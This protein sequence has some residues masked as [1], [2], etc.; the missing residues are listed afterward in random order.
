MGNLSIAIWDLIVL[1]IILF[2]VV[3]GAI[4]GFV[5][6][7]ATIAALV[8][9]FLFAE[10]LSVMIAPLIGVKEPLNRWIA[11]FLL[12]V[13]LSFISFAIARAMKEYIEEAKFTEYDKHM[14][15]VFGL[16]KG[17]AL[18]LVLTFFSV[19][20]SEQAKNHILG[21]HSGRYAAIIMDR[22]HPVMP[23]ELHAILE[24]YIHQLDRDDLD[25]RHDH[26]HDDQ[27]HADRDGQ[28]PT[29]TPVQ[30]DLARIEALVAQLPG[31]HDPDLRKLVV[32]ALL[33]TQ[34]EHRQELLTL[35]A[36]GIPGLTRIIA[37]EW[38]GGKPA[39]SDRDREVREQLLK[40]ISGFYFDSTGGQRAFQ[41][42][43]ELEFSGLPLQ[44]ELAV[45]Q[46]WHADLM[47]FDP[48]PDA[49]TDFTTPIDVRIL[50]QMRDARIPLDTLDASLRD[51]LIGSPYR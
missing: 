36:T 27:S 11:M 31:M 10:S 37:I 21:T 46:D 5:W 19:T 34:P 9:C 24:P 26:D 25:L 47:G 40:E 8:L 33:N 39:D 2:S 4:K 50:N 42:E 28:T 49:S 30:G 43:M 51:R 15:A 16:L 22:L 38:Q 41:E 45:L 23:A 6:Q 13:I 1:G 32:R 14:G 17:V 44:I 48:D 29:P 35:L 18:A 7:I 3:R 12:Y 20:L